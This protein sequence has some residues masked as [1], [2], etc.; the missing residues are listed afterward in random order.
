MITTL[1]VI[2]LGLVIGDMTGYAIHR[3]IHWPHSGVL[4]RNHMHHHLSLYPVHD[5]M[6]DGVYRSAGKHNTMYIFTAFIAAACLLLFV[7]LPIWIAAIWSAEF[8]F[9]GFLNDY[10]HD[11]FHVMG[12]RLEEYDWFLNLR[13]LHY[14]HHRDMTA[15]LGI[16]SFGPDVVFESYYDPLERL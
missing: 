16:F 9:L 8:I 4:Y 12:H 3:F 15:N 5:Y 13:R 14:E 2:A 6:S 11:A 10:L 7:F 1:I